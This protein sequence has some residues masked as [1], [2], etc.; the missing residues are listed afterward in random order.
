MSIYLSVYIFLNFLASFLFLSISLSPVWVWRSKQA[1]LSP[2][3]AA[4]EG[5]DH[6]RGQ[7]ASC[8]REGG[9]EVPLD[10]VQT[11]GFPHPH[12]GRLV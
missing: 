11:A 6:G 10:G 9:H 12:G 4:A 2:F 3:S 8:R 1:L 7:A 5:G